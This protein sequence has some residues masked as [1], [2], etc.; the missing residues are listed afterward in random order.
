[1]SLLSLA[2]HKLI[3]TWTFRNMFQLFH[4][5]EIMCLGYLYLRLARILNER[6]WVYRQYSW[7]DAIGDNSY[8][9]GI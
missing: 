7:Q 8:V 5:A 6:S 2:A 3:I 4:R 9:F 1:M